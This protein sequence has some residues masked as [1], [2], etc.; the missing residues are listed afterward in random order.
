ML[1]AGALILV[2]TIIYSLYN[3]YKVRH[4]VPHPDRYDRFMICDAYTGTMTHLRERKRGESPNFNGNP[5]RKQ[6]LCRILYNW[7]LRYERPDGY[8]C[9]ECLDEK[10]FKCGWL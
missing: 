10:H 8:E 5:K 6:T 4:T 7:D 9:R 1:G 3:V 2:L